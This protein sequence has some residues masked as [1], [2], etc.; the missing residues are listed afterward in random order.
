MLDYI[1]HYFIAGNQSTKK[2]I[3][4]ILSNLAANSEEDAIRLAKSSITYPIIMSII[5]P[6]YSTRKEALWVLSNLTHSIHDSQILES[7]VME[8]CAFDGIFHVFK[9]DCDSGVM[10][11]LAMTALKNL[12]IKSPVCRN[13]FKRLDGEETLESLQFSPYYEIYQDAVY[14]LETFF[15][16]QLVDKEDFEQ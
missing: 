11:A 1:H 8:K 15:D 5:N 14:L 4:W 3:A 12:L 7:L 6:N 13:L 10:M 2:E 16:G 9:L